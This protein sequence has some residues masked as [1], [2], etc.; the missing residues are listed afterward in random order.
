M[1]CTQEETELMKKI[2]FVLMSS[3]NVIRTIY[4]SLKKLS[5]LMKVNY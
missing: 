2:T 3:K 4:C 5:Y 1:F